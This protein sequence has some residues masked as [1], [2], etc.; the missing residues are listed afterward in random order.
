MLLS[1]QTQRVRQRPLLPTRDMTPA[2]VSSLGSRLIGNGAAWVVEFS[3][4][5]LFCAGAIIGSIY[6]FC[7]FKDGSDQA[8]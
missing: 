5:S 7:M 2:Q 1:L 4:M 8:V 3:K 6:L